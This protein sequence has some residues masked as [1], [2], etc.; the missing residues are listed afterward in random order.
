MAWIYLAESE[1][2]Q[3]HSK[4]TSLPSLTV[5]TTDT[6]KP[7]YCPSCKKVNWSERPFG[8][9]CEAFKGQCC[10]QLKLS[11]GDFLAKTF[12]MQD[13]KKVWQESKVDFFS[14][15]SGSQAKL[16]PHSFSWRTYQLLL[17]EEQSELLESF[18]AYGMTVD[19]EFYPLT[20]WERRTIENAGSLWLT[21]TKADAAN[22]TWSVNSRGEPKLS[23]QLKHAGRQSAEISKNL[24]NHDIQANP[25]W[26][27]TLMGYRIGWTDAKPLEMQSSHNKP[28]KRLKG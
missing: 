11:T 19:G 17:F 21:P 27:E 7:Y 16:D 15:S 3:K 4:I 1:D 13:A 9:T 8:T 12:Q 5:K 14:R 23:A 26:I 22:R 2:S 25:D 28:E 6:L 20:M 24:G 18:A 10:L